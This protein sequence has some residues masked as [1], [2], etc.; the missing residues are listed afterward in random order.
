MLEKINN[1]QQ[2]NN[3]E[4]HGSVRSKLIYD[5]TEKLYKARIDNGNILNTKLGLLLGA[6]ATL[7][8]FVLDLNTKELHI[9]GLSCYSCV[10][11]HLI[12]ACCIAISIYFC[13]QGLTSKSVGVIADPNRLVNKEY[14]TWREKNGLISEGDWQEYIVLSWINATQDLNKSAETKSI[15]IRRSIASLIIAMALFSIDSLVVTMFSTSAIAPIQ[16]HVY[17][18][19]CER[20]TP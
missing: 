9:N 15:L 8:K 13:L 18:Y 12:S 14:G 11:I 4:E 7:L 3:N 20:R 2:I 10:A 1:T 6:S 16:P 19:S 17:L 5:Y